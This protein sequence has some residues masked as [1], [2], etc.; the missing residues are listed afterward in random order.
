MVD[1]D[2]AG[3]AMPSSV[4]HELRTPLTA[5]HGYAQVLHR[6]LA[7]D[8]AKSRATSVLLTETTRLSALLN[9]LSEL[10]EV[11]TKAIERTATRVDVR[12]VVDELVEQK[13]KKASGH[14]FE[15]DGT[16]VVRCDARRLTQA[17]S[18]LLDNAVAYSTDGGTVRV[19]IEPQPNGA[20]VS[21]ADEGI[22]IPPEDA[23]QIFRR[24]RRGSNAKRAGVRGLGIG[25]YVARKAIVGEGGQIWHTPGEARGTVFHL[26]VP[27]S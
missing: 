23:D 16:A 12:E 5:I 6:S 19:Q 4:I 7:S 17:L 14:T 10:A 1:E 8:P 3:T 27:N 18:H 25:L 26:S 15:V 9:Q 21:I 11:D 24:Y 13:A 22:G 20:H 2:D